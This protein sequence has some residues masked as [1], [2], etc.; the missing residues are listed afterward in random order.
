MQEHRAPSV[1]DLFSPVAVGPLQIE[2]RIVTAP[3]TRSRARAGNA[4]N[5]LNA[6]YYAQL[7]SREKNAV[8]G[9]GCRS[10]IA[11]DAAPARTL[12][13]RQRTIALCVHLFECG[14]IAPEELRNVEDE[15]AGLGG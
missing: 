4:P 3:L 1:R 10:A 15:S 7:H 9:P 2:N 6:L 11:I 5:K 12:L 8:A 13:I 14:V